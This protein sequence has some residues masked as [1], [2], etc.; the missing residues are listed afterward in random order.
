MEPPQPF[1]IAAAKQGLGDLVSEPGNDAKG[2]EDPAG[3]QHGERKQCRERTAQK[4]AS[5]H[6]ARRPGRI[7]HRPPSPSHA[8]RKRM[9]DSAKAGGIGN[10]DLDG[11]ARAVARFNRLCSALAAGW[12]LL[13]LASVFIRP[14]GTR[15]FG[16]YYMGGLIARLGEWNSLYPIPHPDAKANAGWQAYSTMHPVYADLAR[17]HGVGDV[18]R[19]IHPP[20]WALVFVPLSLLGYEWAFRVWIVLML[21]CVWGVAF[22]SGA[23]A[24]I[25][26]GRPSRLRGLL[27]LIVAAS[28]LSYR[29]VRTGNISALVALS[30]AVTILGIARSQTMRGAIA[31]V[32]GAASK[33]AT[34]LL[35]LLALACRRWK[36]VA[37]A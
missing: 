16:Q 3:G 9:L 7:G 15:D 5:P 8:T 34:V 10:M 25:V 6:G 24:E 2:E 4:Q 28:P 20:P 21:A 30:V 33:Y 35:I 37:L 29:V 22:L 13:I 26:A 23:L 27:I 19:F 17:R 11:S 32:V 14:P 12:M 31:I 1:Q 18:N 36:M